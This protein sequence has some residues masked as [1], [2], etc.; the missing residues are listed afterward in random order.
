MVRR[1]SQRAMV[2]ASALLVA[3]CATR[4]IFREITRGP[5]GT[6]LLTEVGYLGRDLET[7]R[8]DHLGSECNPMGCAWTP[9]DLFRNRDF[10]ER[11]NYRQ[12][13]WILGGK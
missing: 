3:R 1:P 13:P 4:P 7:F 9:S 2:R 8:R 10:D 11:V 6:V 5:S 12:M